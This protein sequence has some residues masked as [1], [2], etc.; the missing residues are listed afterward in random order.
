MAKKKVYIYHILIGR[1][2]VTEVDTFMLARNVK[3]GK[4]Y[5]QEL[6]KD[7]KYDTYKLIKVGTSH[8]LEETQIISEEEAAA[9]RARGAD[10]ADIYREIE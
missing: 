4:A 1:N 5:C 9:L 2:G 7:K 10:K 8:A 3:D 6:Y